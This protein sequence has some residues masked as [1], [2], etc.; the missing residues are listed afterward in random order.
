M[1]GAERAV[2][3]FI[4][5]T[6][7]AA[8]ARARLPDARIAGPAAQGDVLRLVGQRPWAIGIVDGAFEHRPAV[9][10]NEILWALARGI[11]VYGAASLGA[12]RAAELAP[13]GMVGVGAVF[14]AFA[15]GLLEDEDEVAVAHAG[16]EAAHAAASEA[17]VN[18]RAT[19]A[20]AAA[21][22][23]VDEA[24]AAAVA[25]G[26]K[27]LFYPL[28][29]FPAALAAARAAGADEGRLRALEAWLGPG[30]RARV[31]AKRLDAE[32]LLDRIAADR[33]AGAPAPPA[34]FHFA[35]TEAFHELRLAVEGERAV[36]R[37][38]E[39]EGER[40]GEREED[41]ARQDGERRPGR[42]DGRA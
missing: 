37:E 40:A 4:G 25:A 11:R 36:E 3:L 19:L 41:A 9:L 26:A 2:H 27:A 22:G 17:M 10:H 1:S 21:E 14:E 20:R 33:A 7:P 39:R 28:R 34:S 24:T 23:I 30:R 42:D 5:P 38:G 18:V 15:S 8:A 31:D 35:Y 13:Y 16:A 12:L 6:L 32:A 29:T